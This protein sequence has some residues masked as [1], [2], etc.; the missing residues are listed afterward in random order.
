M[1]FVKRISYFFVIPV[2]FLGLGL[3]LGIWGMHFFYPGNVGQLH[4][5]DSPYS[6]AETEHSEVP[7]SMEVSASKDTLC[8]DTE[9][10]LKETDVLRNTS[11][12]TTWKVPHKYIGMN[13][14]RFLESMELYAAHPPLSEVERGFVGLEVLSFSREKVVVRMDYRYLQPSE[15]FY[16]AVKDNE[17][18]V[19][20]QDQS[21]VYINTG[22]PL[23]NL[24]E[25]IQLQIMDML[26]VQDEEAL[27]DFLE[28]YSS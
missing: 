10:V 13:R 15:S 5:E 23:E 7:E 16:L 18:I 28:T 3:F 21:T 25:K 20:L 4:Q 24:P 12:E 11:V 6:G 8:A 2:F 17:V 22:I 9:Y 1:K 14:E 27:Y 19:Y 26:F